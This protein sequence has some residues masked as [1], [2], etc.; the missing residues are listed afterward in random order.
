MVFLIGFLLILLV[1]GYIGYPLFIKGSSQQIYTREQLQRIEEEIE[2][3]IL[4]LRKYP[5]NNLTI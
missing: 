4:V 5:D 3:E 1:A 2:Q